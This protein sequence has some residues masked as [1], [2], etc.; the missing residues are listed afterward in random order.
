M[1]DTIVK[2]LHGARVPFKLASYPSEELEPIAIAS[3]APHAVRVETR[4]LFVGGRLVLACFAAGHTVDPVALAH[5][6]GGAVIEASAPDLPA[7]LDELAGPI[8]PLGSLY[9]VPVILD[10]AARAGTSV[11]FRAFSGS[12]WFEI[13]YDDF[14]R[15]EQ[16]RV[17]S[18]ALAGSLP[19]H[20][21]ERAATR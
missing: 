4:L 2:Y 16:P 13:P 20:R 12:D 6:L 21:D 14:A 1:L 11:V 8:P 9:G 10:Q 3:L 5:E 18:F 17:A 7:P 15:L 19:A